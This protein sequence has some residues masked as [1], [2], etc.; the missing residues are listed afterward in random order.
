MKLQTWKVMNN[1]L[2]GRVY[3]SGV[4]D[5]ATLIHTSPLIASVYDDGLFLFRTENSVYECMASEFDGSDAE[6]NILIENSKDADRQA[7]AKIDTGA[8]R[9]FDE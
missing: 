3:G 4:Y 5:D 7:T 1:E 2:I 9:K 8:L 6:L